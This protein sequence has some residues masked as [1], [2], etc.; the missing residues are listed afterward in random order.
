MIKITTKSSF[1]PHTAQNK[2]SM[3][4][5]LTQQARELVKKRQG[6]YI[7]N[8]TYWLLDRNPNAT[9]I[10]VELA[11]NQLRKEEYFF[12]YEETIHP[13]NTVD[14]PIKQI[15]KFVSK[16]KLSLTDY[17]ILYELYYRKGFKQLSQFSREVVSKG[18][19]EDERELKIRIAKL[20]LKKIL[21]E[22]KGIIMVNWE[23]ILET[24]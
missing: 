21:I 3:V 8:L 14:E 10:E 5:I 6:M 9:K 23:L 18:W 2:S 12:S 13:P 1:T 11:F 20:F 7:G 15:T 22:N 4:A 17:G 24:I 19:D 16:F